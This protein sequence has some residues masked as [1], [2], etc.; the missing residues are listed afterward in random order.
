MQKALILTITLLMMSAA[1]SQDNTPKRCTDLPVYKLLDF[2]VGE[3]DVYVADEKVGTNKIEK[4]LAGCAVLEHWIDSDGNKGESL[5]YIGDDRQWKQ[6]WVTPFANH[7]GGVKEKTRVDIAPAD[8][9]RFQGRLQ[10]PDVGEWLDRTTLTPGE[11][12]TVRQ[13]IETS[14]DN[15][16]TWK[17]GFDAIYRRV[18][19]GT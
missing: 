8:G 18:D 19:T 4:I 16:G 2:W 10:H 17:T 13:V 7:P 5:F 3:W 1:S 15:G 6:V 9:V 11:D 12:G 14:S